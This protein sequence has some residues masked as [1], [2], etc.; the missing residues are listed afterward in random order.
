MHHLDDK[1]LDRLSA[2]AAENYTPP[3]SPSWDALE[4]ILDKELPQE[5][6]KR[7]GIF[8]FF[9]LPALFFAGAAYWYTRPATTGTVA[10][11]NV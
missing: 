5:K 1:D 6:R 3:G 8:W 9:L 4:Q 11:N 7:R 10:V 2:A